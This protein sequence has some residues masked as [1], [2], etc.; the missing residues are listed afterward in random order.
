M[1]RYMVNMYFFIT[2]LIIDIFA[3]QI[4]TKMD[5]RC[6]DKTGP[7]IRDKIHSATA[8]TTGLLACV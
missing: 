8:T 7:R 2:L 5:L 6:F 1:S 3:Q 4:S